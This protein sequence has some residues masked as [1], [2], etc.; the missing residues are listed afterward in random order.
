[1]RISSQNNQ[2]IFNFPQDFISRRLETQFQLLMDK[3]HI[4]Y[5]DVIDYVNAAI[6]DIVFPSVSYNTVEQNLYHGK[7]VNWREAGNVLDKFQGEIDVTFRSVDS[8]LNYF[9]ISQVLTDYY[10]NKKN[11]LDVLSIQVLDK[12][13]DLIYTILMKE[14]MYKSLSEL[15]MAYYATE[16]NEQTFTI[17]F[18]YNFMDIIWELNEISE[19]NGTSI[20][21][22]PIEEPNPRDIK[23]LEKSMKKR[24]KESEEIQEINLKNPNNF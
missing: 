13:G 18:A 14:V 3:N 2:F 12:D 19:T 8:H 15:R 24:L 5:N 10:L 6:K 21:D 1:M 9:I 17:Q 22:I 7:K 11:Y 4:P 23:Q 20:F 16:F